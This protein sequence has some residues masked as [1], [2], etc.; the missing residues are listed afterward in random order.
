MPRVSPD[1]TRIAF[2]NDDGKQGIVWIYDLSGTSAMRQLT[3]GGSNRFPIW[4]ADS[5]SVAFQSDRDGDLA[6]FWQ[7]ADG[8]GT[9]ERLTKPDPGTSHVPD[10]WSPKGDR[11]LFDITKGADISL[12]TF[13]LQDRKAT[14]FGRCPFVN[15]DRR[16]VL[17]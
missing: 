3:S 10:S 9:A 5:K 16:R 7:A 11:F 12:W 4:T 2:G 6:I 1:G 17:A 15:S 8:T 13:S 14:P